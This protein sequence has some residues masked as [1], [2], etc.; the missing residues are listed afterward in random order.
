MGHRSNLDRRKDKIDERQRHQGSSH[1]GY[2][3]NLNAY[4][5]WLEKRNSQGRRWIVKEAESH[6][7]EGSPGGRSSSLNKKKIGLREGFFRWKICNCWLVRGA[8]SFCWKNC[9]L[10]AG[11]SKRC[12]MYQCNSIND[13][14]EELFRFQQSLF[15]VRVFDVWTYVLVGWSSVI[16]WVYFHYEQ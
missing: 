1:G 11:K 13:V 6:T 12:G 16:F 8:T 10:P 14:E 2:G 15:T 7:L 9:D 3:Q 5:R 4:G